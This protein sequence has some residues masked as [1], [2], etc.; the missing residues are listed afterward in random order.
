MHHYLGGD[1]PWRIDI[2]ALS[3]HEGFFIVEVNHE[4]LHFQNITVVMFTELNFFN[5]L[6]FCSIR[7]TTFDT[8]KGSI[9]A[10]ETELQNIIQQNRKNVAQ[11]SSDNT[12]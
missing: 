1:I 12:I 7:L 6:P 10:S 9:V 3:I 8:V 5:L 11:S 2:K 4:Y